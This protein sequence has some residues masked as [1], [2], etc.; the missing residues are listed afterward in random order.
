M[1]NKY[2]STRLGSKPEH[3]AEKNVRIEIFIIT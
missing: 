3:E 1:K 2:F